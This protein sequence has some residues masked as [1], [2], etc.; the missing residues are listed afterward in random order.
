MLLVHFPKS[1]FKSFSIQIITYW[2]NDEGIA[3]GNY[4]QR[5][6]HVYV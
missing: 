1:L 2:R 6:V 3:I 5:S 4:L